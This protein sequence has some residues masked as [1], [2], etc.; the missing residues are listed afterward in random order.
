M[1]GDV[2]IWGKNGKLLLEDSIAFSI[3]IKS[4]IRKERNLHSFHPPMGV[5]L[6]VAMEMVAAS[7][8]QLPLATPGHVFLDFSTAAFQRVPQHASSFF[9]PALPPSA[10]IYGG[11]TNK[12]RSL[13][14]CKLHRVSARACLMRI[15]REPVKLNIRTMWSGRIPATARP[16]LGARS[17]TRSSAPPA[18]ALRRIGRGDPQIGDVWRSAFRER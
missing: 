7:A 6:M 4:S 12:E 9:V 13:R 8:C 5:C 18:Y 14:T 17:L 11:A 3:K 15:C 2:S 16:D 1:Y 10:V